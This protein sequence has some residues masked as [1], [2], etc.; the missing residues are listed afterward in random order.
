[1]ACATQSGPWH[2]SPRGGRCFWPDR[3]RRCR[4]FVAWDSSPRG[5]MRVSCPDLLVP[6]YSCSAQ[7][8]VHFLN[9]ILQVEGT[10]RSTVSC[11]LTPSVKER[12]RDRWCMHGGNRVMIYDGYKV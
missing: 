1:A 3:C 12:V 4:R 10:F 8:Q 9:A 11:Q 5:S 6:D 2:Q 7:G